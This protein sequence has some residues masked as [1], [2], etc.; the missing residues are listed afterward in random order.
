MAQPEWL[1]EIKRSYRLEKE[2]TALLTN[3]VVGARKAGF[4]WQV[5][6]DAMGISRQGANARFMAAADKAK[7]PRAVVKSNGRG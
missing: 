7:V 3:T 6:A 1:A 4:S 2:A 5:I